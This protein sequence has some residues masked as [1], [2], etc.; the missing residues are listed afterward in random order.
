MQASILLVE[1]DPTISKH[2]ACLV[3]EMGHQCRS[4]SSLPV[5]LAELRRQPYDVVI[6]DLDLA[7]SGPVA[8]AAEFR[9]AR[10]TARL[11]GLD[12]AGEHRGRDALHETLD[13]VIPKPFV[14][15]PLL[16]TLPT[17]LTVRGD[18]PTEA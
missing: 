1:A 2:L 7:R 5:A 18:A 8:F 6:V 3:R 10:A 16:E 14:A 12:S 15:E 9:K 17:L 4:V 13:A 11:I